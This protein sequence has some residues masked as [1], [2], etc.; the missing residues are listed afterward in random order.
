MYSL[1]SKENRVEGKDV[2]SEALE[3]RLWLPSWVLPL[4]VLSS[5]HPSFF[6]P[7]PLL[8]LSLPFPQRITR[9]HVLNSPMEKAPWQKTDVFATD[10]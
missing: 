5:L 2:T 7:F 8:P 10:Q 6:S 1:T 3:K 9:G 4:F